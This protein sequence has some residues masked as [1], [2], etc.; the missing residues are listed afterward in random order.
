MNVISVYRFLGLT[1]VIENTERYWSVRPGDALLLH[2]I[3]GALIIIL[4]IWCVLW[5]LLGIG[6][7]WFVLGGI[8]LFLSPPLVTM[9]YIEGAMWWQ[10]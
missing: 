3:T 9:A 8:M 2:I 10:K 1:H 7:T 6:L 4:P 5:L